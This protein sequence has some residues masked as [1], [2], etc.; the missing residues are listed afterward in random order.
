MH[1]SLQNVALTEHNNLTRINKAN[2]YFFIGYI[3]RN[4]LKIGN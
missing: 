3:D 4:T 2:H 1:G